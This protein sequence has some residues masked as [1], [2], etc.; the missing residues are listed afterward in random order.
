MTVRTLP[1]L[2]DVIE[3]NLRSDFNTVSPP[4]PTYDEYKA[5]VIKALDPYNADNEHTE[6]WLVEFY[7]WDAEG[8]PDEVRR[9]Y[10]ANACKCLVQAQH[11]MDR[12]EHDVAWSF[13]AEARYY[14][15]MVDGDYVARAD[16]DRKKLGRSRGGSTTAAKRDKAKEMCIDLLVQKRPQRGWRSY[17]EAAE[18]VTPDLKK[19]IEEKKIKLADVSD[20]VLCWLD[21][22]QRV[23]ATF[24]G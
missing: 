4:N 21:T 23:K 15:G 3:W 5:K 19:F 12:S 22:D 11:A 6:A 10:F 1:Q 2:L 17:V 9:S 24:K 16:A 14:M 18:A 20:Q 7:P 8:L 13:A